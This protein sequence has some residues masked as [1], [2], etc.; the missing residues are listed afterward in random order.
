MITNYFK[1]LKRWK[2]KNNKSEG[3]KL[4][5]YD[6]NSD[7]VALWM[8][9]TALVCLVQSFVLWGFVTVWGSLLSLQPALNHSWRRALDSNRGC[10]RCLF[11]AAPR[12]GFPREIP[13]LAAHP[14]P[15]SMLCSGKELR[16]FV[17]GFPGVPRGQ[18]H[19]SVCGKA[20]GEARA[21]AGT[22]GALTRF[23]VL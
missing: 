15:T 13:H 12:T 10:E 3:I 7:K 14:N 17:V 1:W 11:S 21:P 2:C 20:G 18:R 16:P 5:F 9:G 6:D 23:Q 4:L 22:P 8:G 19:G